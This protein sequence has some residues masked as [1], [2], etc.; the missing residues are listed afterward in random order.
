MRTN[1]LLHVGVVAVG[2]AALVAASLPRT[3]ERGVAGRALRIAE[4]DISGTVTGPAGPE[5][6]VWVIAETRDLP[7]KFA[8]IVVTDDRGRYVI[9]ELPSATYDVW[10][11]GYGLIDSPKRRARPGNTLN[12]R[13]TLAPT[14]QAAAQYYPAGYWYSLLQ[15]PPA[16][17]FPGTGPEG[18]GIMPNV[19][20]QQ[21]FLRIIKN[22][23]CL[24]CHQM[25]NRATRELPPLL[26]KFPSSADAL[27]RRIQS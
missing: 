6:G 7:T 4:N 13:A 24:A 1:R 2:C 23:G 19:R 8:K 15:V 20:S 21:Q 22:G 11:R 27:H 16:S 12:L 14:P 5:A 25:G 18:N 17:D 26:G 10:V 9:P 3:G